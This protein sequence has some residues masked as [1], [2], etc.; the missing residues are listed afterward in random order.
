MT[1][2]GK[3]QLRANRGGQPEQ[4]LMPNSSILSVMAGGGIPRSHTAN[5]TKGFTMRVGGR[6]TIA[7][8][9]QLIMNHTRQNALKGQSRNIQQHFGLPEYN[10]TAG[11]AAHRHEASAESLLMMAK[12]Q[13]NRARQLKESDMK[14]STLY[15][16]DMMNQSLSPSQYY[17]PLENTTKGLLNKNRLM[18]HEEQSQEYS[19]QRA[20]R[21]VRQSFNHKTADKLQGNKTGRTMTSHKVRGPLKAHIVEPKDP[22]FQRSQSP[23]N[24]SKT[25][26][27]S[28]KLDKLNSHTLS[29]N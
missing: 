3:S 26:R 8:I 7:P 18:F 6:K 1:L 24:Q 20:V 27:A 29:P 12:R 4:R 2:L 28:T 23:I 5:Q 13:S 22:S 11:I 25:L 9:Q 16:S 10:T 14:Q 17:A 21:G 19:T 15:S